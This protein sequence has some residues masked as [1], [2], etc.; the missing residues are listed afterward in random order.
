MSM[1]MGASDICS[2]TA[3]GSAVRGWDMLFLK[4]YDSDLRRD[5]VNFI[6]NEDLC[7]YG[8]QKNTKMRVVKVERYGFLV[9]KTS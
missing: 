9:V 5:L 8:L 7:P 2:I 1:I 6:P 3:T 4:N